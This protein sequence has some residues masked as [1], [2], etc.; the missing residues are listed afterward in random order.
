EVNAGRFREDLYNSL[1][2]MPLRLPPLRDRSREDLAELIVRLMDDLAPH[3]PF[4]PRTVDDTALERLLR[5]P[6]PG[7]IRELRNVLERGMIVGR[8]RE[9]LDAD[10]LPADVRARM[11]DGERF[12]ARALDD[13]EREHIDRS[14]RVFKGNR[15]RTAK[16]LGISR[17][18]LIKKIKDYGLGAASSVSGQRQEEA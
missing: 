6:W 2:V 11:G 18:T 15:S 14:L 7:N 8:G 4:A 17:A 12:E 16:A 3:L 13:V 1:A 5:H 9:V 10:T